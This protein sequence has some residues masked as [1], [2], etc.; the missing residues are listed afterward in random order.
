MDY[1]VKNEVR[2]RRDEVVASYRKRRWRS[3]AILPRTTARAAVAGAAQA[4][5]DSL[6]AFARSLRRDEA[7]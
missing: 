5:S 2:A 6:A 1:W 7:A 3:L 4:M